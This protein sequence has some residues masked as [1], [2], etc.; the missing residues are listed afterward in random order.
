ARVDYE[1]GIN[2][3]APYSDYLV[4]NISSPNTPGLRSM[5]RKS[6]L[7]KLLLHTK[8]VLDQMKLDSPPK[9]L[10]KIAP[11]LIES[12][13]K[14]IA[15]VVVDPK[16]GVDGLIVSNTT[17]SRPGNLLSDKRTESGG[18]SG[19]PLREM[20]TEC[21]REMYRLTKGQMPIVGCGGIASGKDAY[22]KIRAGASVVQLY[23]AL[24]FQGFPVVGKI[25][26]E[27]VELLR[28]DGFSNVTEAIGA[29]HRFLIT[30]SI[31]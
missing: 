24:A 26:R 12:E 23:S 22:E 5:Q 8:Y 21:V 9:V 25:K 13:K 14:D 16:Y 7:E 27:L 15:K 29:D 1:I 28:K 19:A 30:S 4:L 17:I 11:D 10:L 2:C 18:L 6:D 20:S 31:H 3:F